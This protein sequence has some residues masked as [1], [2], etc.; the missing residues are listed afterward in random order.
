MKKLTYVEPSGYFTPAMKKILKEG[1]KK[2]ASK[3]TTKKSS[4]K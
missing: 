2:T 3:S 4:K 1:E